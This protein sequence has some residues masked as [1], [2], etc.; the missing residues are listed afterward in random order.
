MAIFLFYAA[1]A[2]KVAMGGHAHSRTLVM[3]CGQNKKFHPMTAANRH[4]R[5]K[6]EQG[7]NDKR[8]VN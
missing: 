8:N 1:G 4:T 3:T 6:K 5:T 2:D 7:P